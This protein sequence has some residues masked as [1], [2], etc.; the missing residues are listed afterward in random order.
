MTAKDWSREIAAITPL[1][2]GHS[3]AFQGA[4][5]IS[6]PGIAQVIE[7][8]SAAAAATGDA[9]V[10][11]VLSICGL[12][13]QQDIISSIRCWRRL[14]KENGK[15][16][17]VLWNGDTQASAYAPQFIMELINLIGGFQIDSVGDIV[18]GETW[19]LQASRSQIAEIRMPLGVQ[20]GDLARCASQS[21][22]A[23]AELYFHFGTVL[24]QSGDVNLAEACYQTLLKLEANNAEA[25]FGL[26]MCYGTTGRWQDALPQLQKAQA[27]QGE[28]QELARWIELAQQQIKN[29]AEP[30]IPSQAA[31]A[32][33]APVQAQPASKIPSWDLPKR[34]ST[35][36]RL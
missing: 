27:L 15:L 16:I 22:P 11:T 36:L 6:I 3:V 7:H 32:P 23:R 2:S 31:P 29:A 25:L 21:L 12:E 8:D 5:P 10:D 20:G 35:G 26:G 13:G 33:A 17:L 1:I 4:C 18:E 9:T 14:L 30:V 24:L 28:N 19:I 34:A